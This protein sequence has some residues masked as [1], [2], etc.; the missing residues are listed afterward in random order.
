MRSLLCLLVPYYTLPRNL[1]RSTSRGAVLSDRNNGDTGKLCPRLFQ[2]AEV[3]YSEL[4]KLLFLGIE[5]GRHSG[6][7]PQAR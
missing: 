4:V 6:P 1:A 2:L 3:T 5:S 7:T